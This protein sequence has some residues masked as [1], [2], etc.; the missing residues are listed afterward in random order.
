LTTE[1]AIVISARI[2]TH[3][4]VIAFSWYRKTHSQQSSKIFR[5]PHRIENATLNPPNPLPNR[6]FQPLISCVPMLL[7]S[8]GTAFHRGSPDSFFLARKRRSTVKLD[9]RMEPHHG[10][11]LK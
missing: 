3:R 8:Q 4:L 6:H 9:F 5:Y 1:T 7:S 2:C 10:V 11:P